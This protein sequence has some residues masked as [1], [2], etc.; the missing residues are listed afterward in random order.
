MGSAGRGEAEVQ[1]W[2]LHG[3]D[4]AQREGYGEREGEERKVGVPG[5]GLQTP[6]CWALEDSTDAHVTKPGPG[7][8]DVEILRDVSR[9]L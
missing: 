4:D 2:V 9:P 3:L 1:L 6:C 5:A 7:P 8:R